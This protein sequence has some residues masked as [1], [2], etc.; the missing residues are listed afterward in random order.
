MGWEWHHVRKKKGGPRW[1]L[2]ASW[3]MHTLLNRLGGSG[4][5][6]RQAWEEQRQGRRHEGDNTAAPMPRLMGL[7]GARDKPLITRTQGS[8]PFQN[9]SFIRNNCLPIFLYL[10]ENK[11]SWKVDYKPPEETSTCTQVKRTQL[12]ALFLQEALAPHPLPHPARDQQW[13]ESK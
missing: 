1:W 11:I 6:R 7:W 5:R 4:V 3:D 13:T 12:K 2:Q 10:H 8:L 9:V